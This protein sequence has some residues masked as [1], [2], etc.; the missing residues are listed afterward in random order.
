MTDFF[1]FLV[2]GISRGSVY[3]L[4]ALGYVIIFKATHILNFGQGALMV[5]GAYFAYTFNGGV[6]GQFITFKPWTLTHFPWVVSLLIA[7]LVSAAIGVGIER[8]ILRRFRGRPAFTIIMA[9]FG[10]AIITQYLVDAIWGGDSMSY[11]EPIGLKSF[12]IAGVPI[13]LA[14][15]VT[16]AVSGS[17]TFGFI[18]FFNHSRLG[19]G[20]RA[21][22]LDQEAALAQG[23][24]TKQI[25][26]LAWGISAALACLAAVLISSGNGR[27]ISQPELAL[28]AFAAFPAIILGGVDSISGAIAGGLIIGVAELLM[29]GYQ[30][31]FSGWLGVDLGTFHQVLP[32]VIML[33][34]L[35][36]RPYGLF[37]DKDVRRV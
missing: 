34:I 25:F 7:M 21:T 24:S 10:I 20:M 6:P 33:V 5:W 3:A 9:T 15:L 27:S 29:L 16:L 23:I 13:T 11:T 37:G 18:M 19:T 28:A 8:F 12:T 31:K 22:A 36:V 17:V 14:D 32:Y 2:Q 35:L 26:A 1:N 4:V 30:A